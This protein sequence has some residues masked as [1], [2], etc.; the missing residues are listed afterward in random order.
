VP[1]LSQGGSP[2]TSQAL[3]ELAAA[4]NQQAPVA[5]VPQSD[6]MVLS[7]AGFSA[8]KTNLYRSNVGQPPVSAANNRTSSPPMFCQNMV[9]IQTRFLSRYR[10]LLAEGATPVP[11]VGDNLLTFLANRLSMSFV[12]LDCQDY[13]LVNPVT[14]TLGDTGAAVAA[15]FDTTSQKVHS[16]CGDQCADGSGS[17]DPDGHA[18]GST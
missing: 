11:S 12:N 15:V 2:G 9:N 16:R 5:L 6:E 4:R 18:R 13:G 7:G 10:T 8:A 14:V 1:D 17:G 3:D